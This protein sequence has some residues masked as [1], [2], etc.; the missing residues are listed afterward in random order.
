LLI[1]ATLGEYVAERAGTINISLEG[2]MLGGAYGAA[3]AS[4]ESGSPVVGLVAGAGAGLL[5]GIAQAQLSHKLDANQFVVGLALT[6]LVLGLTTF[7]FVEIDMDVGRIHVF[8]IPVLSEIPLI[9]QAL[10]AQRWVGYLG[11]LVIPAT[12]WLLQRS[13]WGLEVRSVGEDPVAAD[14]SGVPVLARRRQAIYFCGAMGGL[15]GAYLSVAVVGDFS[16]NMTAGKGFIAIAA[17]LFGGWTLLG[18]V[19][20]AV[21]FGFADAL[22]VALPAIGV[23]QV[24]GPLLE[25]LPFILAFI[26]LLVFATRAR[27]PAALARPFDRD[28][29]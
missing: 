29:G 25:S 21:L 11:L 7:L 5:V 14:V 20:G 26:G 23:D 16:Q 6:T 24:P 2:M 9:G 4:S 15:S 8:E 19:A 22:K 28:G 27:K 3:I 1:F 13:T 12:W 10:F 18:A 17:V